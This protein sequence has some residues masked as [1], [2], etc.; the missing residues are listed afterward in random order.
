MEEL[1]NCSPPRPHFAVKIQHQGIQGPESKL[2]IMSLSAGLYVHWRVKLDKLLEK[3]SLEI[4]SITLHLMLLIYSFHVGL[5]STSLK[6]VFLVSLS[7][8][9][10]SIFS[11]CDP[12]LWP[13]IVAYESDQDSARV[14]HR[15][16]HLRRR[17]FCS[18]IIVQKVS[19]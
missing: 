6:V 15:G 12:E 9:A 8:S 7:L 5:P 11:S 2:I 14:D 17:S 19:C 16:K 1:M 10:K 18:K 4:A 13:I 3:P